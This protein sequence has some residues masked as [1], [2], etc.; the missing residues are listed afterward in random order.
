MASLSI[1]KK[2]LSKLRKKV[3]KV[4]QAGTAEDLAVA[5][6]QAKQY[7]SGD[8]V[9]TNLTHNG[10]TLLHRA[11][12]F[13]NLDI[14]KFLV[15]D[16]KLNV[17]ERNNQMKTPVHI[18]ATHN[19]IRSLEF[20]IHQGNANPAAVRTFSWTPLMYAASRG[21][22]ESIDILVKAGVNI[23]DVNKEHMTA[24]Y[25]ASREGWY[26]VVV[27]LVKLGANVNI[28]SDTTKR[29]PLFCALMHDHHKIVEFFVKDTDAN[30]NWRDSSMNTIWHEIAACNSLKCFKLLLE[31]RNDSKHAGKLE[32]FI[33][34]RCL[35]SIG[36]HPVHLAA[37]E[38]HS[39]ILECILLLNKK[40]VELKQPD[41][42]VALHIASARGHVKAVEVLLQFGSDVNV[43]GSRDRTPLDLAIGF[44]HS[45]VTK[46]LI[47][48]GAISE[49]NNNMIL[50]DQ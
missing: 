11:A 42:N 3:L 35:N 20:L 47:D 46:L 28:F 30:L 5:L 21:H 15:I 40:F 37:A 43:K 10:E 26:N 41:S 38:G 16:R 36:Q 9:L 31:V 1:S 45:E 50:N 18:A 48:N 29:T 19:S 14:V 25:L 6:D 39:G 33:D 8:N 44:Q 4:A 23:D 17:N 34:N 7:F 49:N 32:M 27:Y 2:Q 13:D 24:L 22:I 12:Q